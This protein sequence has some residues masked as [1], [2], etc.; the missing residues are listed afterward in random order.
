MS[1]QRKQI[2]QMLAEGKIS[3]EDADRLL[4]ALANNTETGPDGAVDNDGKSGKEAKTKK[5]SFLHISVHG[6]SGGHDGHRKHENV[7]IKIPIMLLKAGVKLG[8]L[9]PEST[10][11]KFNSHLSDHGLDLDLNNLDSEKLDVFIQALT[12][13]SIDIVADDE[14]VSI[15]CA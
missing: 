12:E 6:G 4:A 9:V 15:R 14:V 13:S 2:L 8:S 5:P 7:D 10:R 3:A 1:E 11:N